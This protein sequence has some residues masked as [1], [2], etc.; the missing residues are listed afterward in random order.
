MRAFPVF[1]ICAALFPLAFSSA[2]V[3]IPANRR[4]G[5]ELFAV[6][7]PRMLGASDASWICGKP[8]WVCAVSVPGMYGYVVGEL[9]KGPEE[10][11]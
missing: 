2:A 4:S 3:R 11:A 9:M 10:R 1:V 6:M 7:A 5:R 8:S